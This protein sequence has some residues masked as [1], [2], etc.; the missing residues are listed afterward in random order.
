MED[1]NNP[2][3]DDDTSDSD[4]DTVSSV[5]NNKALEDDV[6][7]NSSTHSSSSSDDTWNALLS[8][9]DED[10][11]IVEKQSKQRRNK[12]IKNTLMGAGIV[13]LAIVVLVF[14]IEYIMSLFNNQN[15]QQPQPQQSVSQSVNS[16]YTD[17]NGGKNP[18][19]SSDISY[20]SVSGNSTV[21]VDHRKITIKG[22]KATTVIDLSP[23]QSDIAPQ[24]CNLKDEASSCYVGLS[25]YKD[26]DVDIFAFRDASKTSLLLTSSN[27]TKQDI[28]GT[29]LAYSQQVSVDS[30]T[31]HALVLVN[32]DQTGIMLVSDANLNT[33]KNGAL[34]SSSSNK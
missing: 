22:E 31:K 12:K 17:S 5:L 20:A 29:V 14:S 32:S 11:E 23:L 6:E 8:D 2:F 3:L 13:I 15:N 25:K 28:Q 9:A 24:D 26:K 4:E 10:D 19:S 21:S 16:A 34:V 18:A 30:K 33:L 1:H 27:I 7:D